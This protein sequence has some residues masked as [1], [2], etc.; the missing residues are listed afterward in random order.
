[1]K[2]LNRKSI[3]FI[4]VGLVCILLLFITGEKKENAKAVEPEYEE[5]IEQKLSELISGLSGVEE[6][7]VM[8]TIECGTEYVYAVDKESTAETERISYYSAGEEDALLIKEISP[9]IKGVGVVCK[10]SQGATA[11][12]TITE[13]VSSV[14]DL[15]L[16]RIFVDVW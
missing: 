4:S 10:A 16:N 6:V 12:K 5:R 14:L 8:V 11:R 9:V 13:L 15:P 3:I 7:R 2:I 1:M